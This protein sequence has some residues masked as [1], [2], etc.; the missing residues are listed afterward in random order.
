[1]TDTSVDSQVQ[2]TQAML[3]AK[4]SNEPLQINRP[5][6]LE[7]DEGKLSRPVRQWRDGETRRSEGRKVRP[8]PTITKVLVRRDSYNWHK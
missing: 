6:R 8:V 3:Y 2:R 4:A 7:P 1:M 5:S